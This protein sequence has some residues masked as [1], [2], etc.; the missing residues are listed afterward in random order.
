MRRIHHYNALIVATALA[1]TMPGAETNP[2]KAASDATVSDGTSSAK[3]A[4]SCWAI[5][6][7][8]PASADG[9][10]WL[11]T[12]KLV[13]PQQ[14]YCDMTTDGGGYVLVGRGREGWTF[15]NK[16]Q[17][18]ASTVRTTPT[19]PAAFVPATLTASTIDALLNGQSPAALDD[20]IR[21]RR[22][23]DAEG[24]TWQ[25]VRMQLDHLTKWSWAMPGGI[26]LKSMTVDGTNYPFSPLSQYDNGT[27]RDANPSGWNNDQRV[28]TFQW[29]PHAKKQGFSYGSSVA[30]SNTSTTYLWSHSTE[31]HA[32]P[33][34]Q[35]WLRP[36]LTDA[37][38]GHTP[39][40]ASGTPASSVRALPSNTPQTFQWGVT[41]VVKPGA[42][43]ID[44]DNLGVDTTA[45]AQNTVEFWMKW[46]GKNNQMPF[47][48]NNYS[49][50]LRSDNRFG[51]NSACG[52]NWGVPSTGFANRW[53]HVAAVFTNGNTA[54]NKLYIDGAEQSL[55]GNIAC[56]NSASTSARLS[57]W[58]QD[59]YYGYSGNIDELAIYSGAL[60]SATIADHFAIGSGATI[61]AYD[62]AVLAHSPLTYLRVG[63]S[64]GTTMADASG[65]NRTGN[66]I[67]CTKAQSSALVNDTNKAVKFNP[68][69]DPD[70]NNV[71]PVYALQQVGNTM[72]VG[73]QFASV[74]NGAAGASYNQKFLAAFDVQTGAWIPTF[75]PTL[76]GA[77]W[78][79]KASPDGK[80]IVGG[81]FTSINGT[82]NTAGLAAIDPTTGQVV[83]SWTASLAGT[84]FLGARPHVRAL[85]IQ[86]GW[87]YVA[88]SFN[89]VVGGPS[90]SSKSAGG[91]ARVS[92]TDGT[93]DPNFSR[94]FD[95]TIMDVDASAD[96]T[97]VYTVGFFKFNGA[98]GFTMTS[99]SNAT[100]V[101]DTI[102]GAPVPGM[103]QYV[104]STANTSRQWQQ[105]I[106]EYNGNTFQGGSEHNFA[107]Y[108]AASYSL[109]RS[110]IGW[111]GGD[112]QASTARDGIVYASCHCYHF[113][114]ADSTTWAAVYN[115]SQIDN[116]NWLSAYDA[117]TF[118]RVTDFDPNWGFAST[119]E[120]P[121]EIEF[122]SFGCLWSG[123]D[124]TKGGY[125]NGTYD[126]LGGFARFCPRDS[127][128]PLTPTNFRKISNST[129]TV[130]KWNA[131]TDD[132][133]SAPR[134]EVLLEDRVIATVSGLT[135]TV[136]VPGRYFVRAI[137]AGTNRS[138]STA[139]VTIP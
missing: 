82:S 125:R 28:W 111:F 47:G 26:W 20:G 51:F 64:V 7:S 58:R 44:L 27:T 103:Q 25:E 79:L 88:G 37:D 128:A 133:N 71:S 14:F 73:G 78:E 84:R 34:A 85:D 2:A 68:S 55:G 96:G 31:G 29:G 23:R 104:P 131:A 45:G 63:D 35:V 136:T 115:Y 137:D 126:W 135:Y 3:A 81:N 50:W 118:D 32:S 33:F 66:C 99:P 119:G 22:A 124:I 116:V 9:L 43:S 121:W 59:S 77:V 10:Y 36:K 19:G 39:I 18:T 4:P 49:L 94:H 112:Y 109:I 75:T 40:P 13:A 57:S 120:G 89:S 42:P 122:D 92:L 123:G 5:K 113:S 101:L 16:G 97:R 80:L 6:E 53:V 138:A 110:H 114:Y 65:N 17:G 117:S 30:G 11:L 21:I 107:K 1:F 15:Q 52:D 67:S 62:T 74:K 8:F 12:T 87:L 60:D 83:S 54:S 76:D 72:F 98:N 91:L 102:T 38:M 132:S 108:D 48:F 100:A 70:P 139:A 41:G 24:A 129:T 69:L 95:N 105:T 56:N 86:D 90:L 106:V 46:S 93:P 134:Y 61:G 130:V 127:T